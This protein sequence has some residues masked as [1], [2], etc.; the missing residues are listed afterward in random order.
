[1]TTVSSGLKGFNPFSMCLHIYSF[2]FNF[3]KSHR[4]FYT[5]KN[6]HAKLQHNDQVKITPTP[7]AAFLWCFYVNFKRVCKK[8][9]RKI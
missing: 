1:M 8:K 3:S 9:Y 4:I 7:C 6:C 5:E 2:F